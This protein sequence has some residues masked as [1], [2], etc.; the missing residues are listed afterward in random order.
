M[1]KALYLKIIAFLV[2]SN[3]IVF[4]LVLDLMATIDRGNLVCEHVYSSQISGKEIFKIEIFK[5]VDKIWQYICH[6]LLVEQE[7]KFYQKK[8][9]GPS[10]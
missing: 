2:Q 4:P 8:M 7:N 9:S 5:W 10:W 3:W 1:K 6:V